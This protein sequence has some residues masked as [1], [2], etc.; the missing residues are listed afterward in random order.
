MYQIP[1][2]RPAGLGIIFR[3]TLIDNAWMIANNEI[4]S[5]GK[6]YI[7]VDQNEEDC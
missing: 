5:V 7:K 1:N 6:Q 4:V 2:L 3:K